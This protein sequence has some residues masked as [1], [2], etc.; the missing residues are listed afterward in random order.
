[1]NKTAQQSS[2]RKADLLWTSVGLLFGL[3]LGLLLGS[4]GRQ[5]FFYVIA[6]LGVVWLVRLYMIDGHGQVVDTRKTTRHHLG[7][8]QAEQTGLTNWDLL[9]EG[10]VW[11]EEQKREALDALLLKQQSV[12]NE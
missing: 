6:G 5:L 4:S 3:A 2:N 1:M 10:E 9:K 8:G 12:R 11:S 7:V